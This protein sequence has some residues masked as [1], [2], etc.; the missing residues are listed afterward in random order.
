MRS[1]FRMN[2]LMVL[3]HFKE[4]EELS[5]RALMARLRRFVED[6][7]LSFYKI[8]SRVNTSGT[9]LSMWLAG[10]ARPQQGKLAEIERLLD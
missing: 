4:G 6:S 9:M 2:G 3:R 5:E 8:A 7:D 1:V 10:T